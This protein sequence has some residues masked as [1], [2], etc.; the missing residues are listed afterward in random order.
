[1]YVLHYHF[2]ALQTRYQLLEYKG[3]VQIRN[4]EIHREI[5]KARL[6]VVQRVK[7]GTH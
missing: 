2:L 4:S 3:L 5:S 7:V 6:Y 1:M